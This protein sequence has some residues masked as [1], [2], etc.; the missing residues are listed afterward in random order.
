MTAKTRYFLIGSALVLVLGLGIGV[1]AYY[2]G[3][4]GGLFA[5]GP[6]PKE[7]KYVPEDAAVVAYADVRQ[8]MTSEL[9]QHLRQLDGVTDEGRSEFRDQTGIDIEHD[10]DY[11]VASMRGAEISDH[12][13][14]LVIA[15]G[16]FDQGR[17]EALAVEH[18]GKVTEYRGKRM[19][20]APVDRHRERAAAEAPE[21]ALAFVEPGLMAMGSLPAVQQALE[22]GAAGRNVTDNAEMMKFVAEMQSESMW[23]V[24]RFDAVRAEARLPA[25][26]ENRIPPITWFAASGRVNGGVQAT[27]KV[28]ARDEQAA[29][30]LRDIVRGFV[31]LAKMQAGDKT[32]AAALLPAIELGGT[33]KTVSVSFAVSTA[34]LDAVSKGGA[35]KREA[36]PKKE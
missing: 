5:Q 6:G 19:V 23:A 29:D 3:V 2:G 30:S 22:T 26:V 28:D 1:V 31:A 25:E 32:E 8:V 34:L 24:G 36:A 16:R 18:G 27:V 9:R 21:F 14:G 33:G 35:M 17:L 4:S 20:M 10:I 7:L 12:A 13:D 15:R 11:V